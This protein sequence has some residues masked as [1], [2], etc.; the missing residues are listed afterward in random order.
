MNKL[1]L[2]AAAVAHGELGRGETTVNNGG[3]EVFKYTNGRKGNWCAAFLAWCFE[4]AQRRLARAGVH[5][6]APKRSH[7]AKRFTK[8][9]ARLG[10]F[11]SAGEDPAPGDVIAWHRFPMGSWRGHVGIVYGYYATTD[12]LITI[13]GNAGKFPVKVRYKRYKRGKWRKRL[14][15]IARMDD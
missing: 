11:L 15:K 14:Y 2:E 9:V 1:A 4:E 12:T 8:N 6:R 13:E 3:P 7:G 10:R 5:S